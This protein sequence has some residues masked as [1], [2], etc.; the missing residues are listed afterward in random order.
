[1]CMHDA[2]MHACALGRALLSL[3]GSTHVKHNGNLFSKMSKAF[4]KVKF[5]LKV[6]CRFGYM[7]SNMGNAF[8]M[9]HRSDLG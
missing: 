9:P 1:M 3:R 8:K 6:D 4:P 7:H 2:C 5:K